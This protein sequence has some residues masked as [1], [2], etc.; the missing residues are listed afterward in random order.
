[1][2][3]P[4]LG[5][6]NTLEVPSH[7]DVRYTWQKMRLLMVNIQKSMPRSTLGIYLGVFT[8]HSRQAGLILKLTNG[9][10]SPKFHFRPDWTFSTLQPN[11]FYS[12]WKVEAGLMGHRHLVTKSSLAAVNKLKPHTQ[13]MT[14]HPSWDE[15]NERPPCKTCVQKRRRPSMPKVWL[16]NGSGGT[17]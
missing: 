4:G 10:V 7:L 2:H 12:P 16:P 11:P 9:T 13:P 15:M 14:G 6:D 8:L 5:Q 17:Q 1:M 3:F